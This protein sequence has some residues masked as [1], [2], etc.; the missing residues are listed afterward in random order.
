MSDVAR[1]RTNLAPSKIPWDLIRS[2]VVETYG[3]KVDDEGDFAELSSLVNRILTL[4]AFDDDYKLVRS[5]SRREGG[6]SSGE[7]KEDDDKD[8]DRGLLVPS[9]TRMV[10]FVEW[11]ERLP[12]REPPSYLG[13][14]ANAEKLLLVGHGQTTIENV[15]RITEMLEEGEQLVVEENEEETE[16]EEGKN[17]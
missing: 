1:E 9:G 10:D 11:V 3:G 15:N 8:D 12:E 2:L 5:G 4:N 6:V 14:P 17:S 7:E 13:L 16:E